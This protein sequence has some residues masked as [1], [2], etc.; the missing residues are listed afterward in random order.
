[1]SHGFGPALRLGAP[2]VM[3]ALATLLFSLVFV[4]VAFN[5]LRAGINMWPE[6][7]RTGLP[8]A[9]LTALYLIASPTGWKNTTRPVIILLVSSTALLGYLLYD[10]AFATYFAY[11]SPPLIAT[12]IGFFTSLIALR[13]TRLLFASP[14]R[15]A[16]PANA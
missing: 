6:M 13:V 7:A 9:A 5:D 8:P 2:L 11:M 3:L 4:A 1:M 15:N 16:A 10:S 14:I 12:F